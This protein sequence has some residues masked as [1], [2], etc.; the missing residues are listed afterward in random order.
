MLCIRPNAGPACAN[1][2][3]AA[4]FYRKYF[5]PEG[6]QTGQTRDRQLYGFSDLGMAVAKGL[7][8]KSEELWA[9]HNGY[10]MFSNGGIELMCGYVES[11]EEERR[12]AIRKRLK[13]GVPWGVTS[14]GRSDSVWAPGFASILLGSAGLVLLLHGSTRRALGANGCPG[15]RSGLRSRLVVDG[16]ERAA[17]RLAQRVADLAGRRRVQHP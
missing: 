10:T 5:A 2:A 15:D 11:L 3:G 17:G 9:M 1:G 16:S 13:I 7:G 6:E 12:D 14:N 4:T 8:R